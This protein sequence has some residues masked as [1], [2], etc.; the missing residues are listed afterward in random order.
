M[1]S[2]QP[3]D[4][5]LHDHL[6]IA[7][8]YGYILDV[9]RRDGRLQQGRAIDTRTAPGGIEYLVLATDSGRTEVA[10]HEITFVTVRT[11]GACFQELNFETV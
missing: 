1:S 4:C 5:T 8:T 2:I 7:C 9:K 3:I 10:M 11:P 6:E